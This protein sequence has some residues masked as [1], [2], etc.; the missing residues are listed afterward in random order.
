MFCWLAAPPNQLQ[1]DVMIVKDNMG[2]LGLTVAGGCDTTAGAPYIR[3]LV[4]GGPASNTG[5]L[6]EGDFLCAVDEQDVTQATHQ[7][8]IGERKD[9]GLAQPV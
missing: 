1:H 6:R 4:P 8:R 2:S 7:V 5:Q 9:R 3:S